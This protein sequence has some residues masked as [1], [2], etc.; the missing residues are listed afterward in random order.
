[1][2]HYTVAVLT[3]KEQSVEDLLTP[4]D[5]AIDVAPY[6]DVKKEDAEKEIEE[7]LEKSPQ[8][9]KEYKGMTWAEQV[10]RYYGQEIDQ[11]GNILSTYNPNSKWDWYDIGGRWNNLLKTKDGQKVNTCLLKDLDLSPDKEKYNDA[12][13]FWEIIVEGQPLKDGEEEPFNWYKK[14]YYLERY[15]T[16]E[17]YA[18]VQSLF[19]T[20]AILTDKGEWLE[21]GRMGWFGVSFATNKEGKSW[22][23]NY[24]EILKSMDKD[25]RITIVDCHI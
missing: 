10:M 22:D 25:L 5:E 14:E 9:A 23:E 13:R 17:N 7:F 2:S 24:Q 8:Y 21:S 1:M 6:I 15:K 12:V 18:K 11:D 3:R 16:K 20:Y 19:S 4:Y